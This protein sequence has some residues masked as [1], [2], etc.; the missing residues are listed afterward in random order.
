MKKRYSL[1][2]ALPLL[3]ASCAGN[4][5]DETTYKLVTK[6]DI[7]ELERQHNNALRYLNTY[8]YSYHHEI[9]AKELYFDKNIAESTIEDIKKNVGIYRGVFVYKDS[10]SKY[11]GNNSTAGSKEVSENKNSYWFIDGDSGKNLVKR[12]AKTNRDQEEISY[13]K[14]IEKDVSKDDTEYYFSVKISDPEYSQYISD[15]ISTL[16]NP[17][18]IQISESEIVSKGYELKK[19]DEI[20]NIDYPN[21][22]KMNLVVFGETTTLTKYSYVSEINSYVCS[23]KSETF[24]KFIITDNNLNTLK[25][26]NILES[27][28][29]TFSYSYS[30][31]PL[32][33]SGAPLFYKE[34]DLKQIEYAPVLL[35]FDDSTNTYNDVTPEIVNIT[36]VY[37][38][39]NPS[40]KGYAYYMTAILSDYAYCIST[41]IQYNQGIFEVLGFQNIIENAVGY[42][43]QADIQTHPSLFK[44]YEPLTAMEIIVT[45]ELSATNIVTGG[46]VFRAL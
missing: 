38:N 24:T 15:S 3:M 31:S 41:K 37:R 28:S 45:I 1:L 2:L 32:A 16:S 27:Y 35:S 22:S 42:I 8:S 40:Y 7:V 12:E 30:A 4:N 33:Y 17:T 5:E 43:G 19:I 36:D 10:I 46:L 44:N 18:N 20:K 21:D 34:P 14:I 11:I 39:Q 26:K 9:N 25:E 13:D 6:E 23:E 29:K